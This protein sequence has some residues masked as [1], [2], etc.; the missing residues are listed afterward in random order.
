[1]DEKQLEENF[2]ALIEDVDSHRP[3]RPGPFITR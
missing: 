3:K 1:M 2:K